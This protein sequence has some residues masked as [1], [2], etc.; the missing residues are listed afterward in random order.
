MLGGDER[1]GE[2]EQ[3]QVG[4][5]EGDCG[6]M[7]EGSHSLLSFRACYQDASMHR[8]HSE[9]DRSVAT[10]MQNAAGGCQ[11]KAIRRF[12]LMSTTIYDGRLDW[13][14]PLGALTKR[15]LRRRRK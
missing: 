4:E 14:M 15:L 9:Q 6:R 12:S 2:V 3:I 10:R 13:A 5:A 11:E 7:S 8:R 1:T